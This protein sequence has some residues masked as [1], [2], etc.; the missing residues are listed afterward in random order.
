M[1]RS[2]EALHPTSTDCARVCEPGR[3]RSLIDLARLQ[4]FIR[5]LDKAFAIHE[6]TWEKREKRVKFTRGKKVTLPGRRRYANAS[7]RR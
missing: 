7:G 4:A 6:T 3:V 2:S 1:A 5:P